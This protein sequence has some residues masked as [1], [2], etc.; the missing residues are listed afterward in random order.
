LKKK[1]RIY[2]A[3]LTYTQQ[4]IAADV[5][6]QAIGSI[7]SYLH[8]NIK[9][10]EQIKLFKYP[11][12]LIDCLESNPI[13][14]VIGFSNYIWNFDLSYRFCEIIK[15]K[16]PDIITIFGGPNFP[17]IEEEFKSFLI[18]HPKIDFYIQKEGEIAFLELIKSIYDL[19][20]DKEKVKKLKKNSVFS[21]SSES[22]LNTSKTEERITDLD[23]IPSPYSSGLLDEFFD[24]KL[25]PII[26]TNRG[27]PFSCTFCV[28]GLNYYNKIRTNTLRKL[29][30][31]VEYIGEKMA[32]ISKV[33][34][35]NDL[36]IADSNF[37]M[38]KG[39]IPFCTELSKSRK[40][41]NWPEYIN[42]ATGKNQKERVLEAS[43]IIDGVL[44]LSGSVQSLDKDVLANVKRAN[45]SAEGLMDLALD[46]KSVGANSYS[47]II[48]ALPGDTKEKHYSSVKTVIEAGFTNVLLFQLMILP[49][50]E[51]ATL[52][53]KKK[54]NMN[55]KYRVLPRC[56]GDY[57]LFGKQIV[58][59]EIEEICIGTN[60]LEFEDYVECRKMHLMVSI[61]YND[62]LFY[63]ILKLI[64]VLDLS[65]WRWVELLCSTKPSKNLN[66]LFKSFI[67]ATKNELW[68][69]KDEL[70]EYVAKPGIINK[71]IDG[72]IGNNLLFVHKTRAIND[73]SDSIAEFVEEVT[74][75][76]LK[77][78]GDL[79]LELQTFVKDCAKYHLLSMKNLFK[80]KDEIPQGDFTFD[81]QSFLNSNTSSSKIVSKFKYNN[82][83]E[84]QFIHSET[85]KDII[86]RFMSLFGS[87][88]VAIGRILT[89]VHTKKIMRN[90][91]S[92]YS[93][94]QKVER[95]SDFQLSG[96]Q[97]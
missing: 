94:R 73:Y 57:K 52:E 6:P 78:S 13:P 60:T 61:F 56:Y 85:Q 9:L 20:F 43:R 12:K 32:K 33:G 80:N 14:D 53:T 48:L 29:G 64:R 84:I 45:I 55:I 37:G 42:V 23:L 67:D 95:R 34:G 4:T 41:Y 92:N 77:E 49:G 82:I 19:K 93:T 66:N 27:C 40:N 38:Y 39:D 15:E 87:S 68:D 25:T 83:R 26:Q 58:S 47:E 18:A 51:L 54:F 21:I 10:E 76:F 69:S 86:K 31:E 22:I 7:A 35:R 96:L 62:A 3:D 71:L 74:I 63:S 16:Y 24:G 17:I 79:N 70:K 65:A 1:I 2:L 59:A 89:K 72:E 91:L 50:T 28:E 46:A 36:F 81:I 88:D 8:N 75:K 11:E 44:R 97:N 90:P 5:I 30:P